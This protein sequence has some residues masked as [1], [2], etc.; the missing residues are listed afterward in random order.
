L[1]EVLELDTDSLP[2]KERAQYAYYRGMTHFRLKR[3]LD[4]RHWLG[5]ALASEKQQSGSLEPDQLKLA[6]ETIEP[7]NKERYGLAE[8]APL[9][10]LPC[11]AD[12]DCGKDQLCDQGKCAAAPGA[13]VASPDA[14]GT[15]APTAAP[16]KAGCKSDGDCPPEKICD[17]G[18]CIYR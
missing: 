3:K 5:V 9:G 14:S 17:K 1:F 10:E 7:L 2:P 13:T 8:T 15:A 6:N 18:T 11:K 16:K 12:T 4:A